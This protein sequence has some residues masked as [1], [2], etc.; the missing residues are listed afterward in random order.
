[1]TTSNRYA[2]DDADN[3][4]IYLDLGEA[5]VL[6]AEIRGLPLESV[7]QELRDKGLSES[8]ITRPYNAAVYGDADI[9][10][11]AAALLVGLAENQP[12]VDGTSA[13]RSLSRLRS[14]M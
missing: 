3:G 7:S 6:H 13:R 11:Q 8:A 12:F 9:A 5:L 2:L 4:Y 10:E 14:S 1:M